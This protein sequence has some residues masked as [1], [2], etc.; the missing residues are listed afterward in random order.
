MTRLVTLL[1]KVSRLSKLP[2]AM[3]LA[4]R[5]GH[6]DKTRQVERNKK[7]ERENGNVKTNPT[8]GTMADYLLQKLKKK[9]QQ[10]NVCKA[11]VDHGILPS[12]SETVEKHYQVCSTASPHVA[13]IINKRKKDK[14]HAH[15]HPAS[16]STIL[17]NYV[18]CR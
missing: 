17:V 2:L 8:L 7:G 14:K 9:T 4:I 3:P 16:Q 12:E 5:T 15:M 18:L 11:G 10:K 1:Q 6:H 13:T